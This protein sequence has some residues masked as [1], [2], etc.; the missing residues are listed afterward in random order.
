MK[1]TI[2][3]SLVAALAVAGLSTTASAGGLEEA[4]KGVSISG[5]ME[6]E[7]DYTKTEVAGGDTTTNGWD[8]DWDIT[9]KVPVGDNWT[10]IAGF[11]ADDTENNQNGGNG[12]AQV[13]QTKYY[14]QYASG[15]VVAM[16]GKMGM[17]GAP[18]YDDERA[19]GVVGIYN[20]GPV[21]IAAAHFN[22]T[23]GHALTT[24]T[25]VSAAALIAGNIADTGINASLWYGDVSNVGD[26]ISVNVNGKVADMVNFDIRHTTVDYGD[27]NGGDAELTKAVLSA[28]I[29]AV[30]VRVGYGTTNDN[31]KAVYI[32]TDLGT[33]VNFESVAGDNDAAVT[34]GLEQLN[35]ADLNDADVWYIGAGT[36]IAGAAVNLDYIDGEFGAA[37]T[38]FDELLLDV[39]Y[40]LTKSLTLDAFYSIAELGN[41]DMDSASVALEY[42]F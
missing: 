37:N 6:V 35:I 27:I 33:T 2:K 3:M 8:Y 23:A 14:F 13:T 40:K 26:S 30:N 16:V 19:S 42:K 29:E 39:E 31:S 32:G 38:D 34:F 17:A 36:T 7:Y 22:A 1:N 4:I 41:T 11:Q 25:D 21:A 24:S 12:D 28:D 15:P 10:A 18:W 5:K 9:V 20:A